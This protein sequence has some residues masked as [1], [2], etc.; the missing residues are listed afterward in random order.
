LAQQ[1]SVVPVS[2]Y[3]VPQFQQPQRLLLPEE[4]AE[5]LGLS[6]VTVMRQAKAGTLPSVRIGKV[7][8]FRRATIDRWVEA[9]EAQETA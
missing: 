5:I 9:R 3:S 7:F 4:V 6:R 1:T 8:R 2:Q